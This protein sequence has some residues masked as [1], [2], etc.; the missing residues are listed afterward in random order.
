MGGS[1]GREQIVG[2][3]SHPYAFKMNSDYFVGLAESF[4]QAYGVRFEG[5]RDGVPATEAERLI[6]FK[7]NVDAVMS[8]MERRPGLREWIAERVLDVAG[9][10]DRSLTLGI[11]PTANPF[12]DERLRVENL[13]IEPR[14]R[15]G[16]QPAHRRGRGAAHRPVPRAGGEEG[17]A[18]GR[19]RGRRLAELR[20]R[21]AFHDD[22]GGSVVVDQRREGQPCSATTTRSTTPAARG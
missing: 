22:G 13:P 12:L 11:D 14:G 10:L 4:E 20:H 17:A 9:T 1:A 3:P 18:A 21:R 7:T 8:V 5:V 15:R 19:Q 2:Y 6:Q 16:A